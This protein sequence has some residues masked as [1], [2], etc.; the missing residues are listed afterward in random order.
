MLRI[1]H[2]HV[3]CATYPISINLNYFVC[4][5][6]SASTSICEAPTNET[7][8]QCIQSAKCHCALAHDN[9]L[10]KRYDLRDL[11]RFPG[12]LKSKVRGLEET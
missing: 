3:V 12:A 7:L 4:Q 10:K 1:F 6:Y 9:S 8:I 11:G 5:K 2:I